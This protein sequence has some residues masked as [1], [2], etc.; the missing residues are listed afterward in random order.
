MSGFSADW[1]ALREPFDRAARAA[2]PPAAFA[3]AM[4]A[5]RRGGLADAPLQVVDLGSG[6]GANLRALAPRLGG[7]QRW[8]LVDHDARLLD[9]VPE[10]MAAW[11]PQHGLQ[12]HAQGAGLLLAG[13]ALHLDIARCPV[14]LAHGLD[15]VPFA[16]VQ[17]V[18][19]S[20]L[21]DLVSADWLAA[22]VGRCRAAG[23]AVWW[24][25]NVDERMAWT[26]AA[27]DDAPVHRAFRAHQ[28][29]DK[30]F[31]PALGPAAAPRAAALLAA[32][33]YRVVRR[34]TDW[35]IDGR[36]GALDRS[37]LRAM[38]EGIGAAAAEQAPALADG[39]ARWQAQ[40]C[41]QLDGLRL[42]VGHED[43]M[44]WLP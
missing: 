5:G 28:R 22:L 1:L 18:T 14:E 31:G 10:A 8:R 11:A 27:P 2:G 38:V 16:G 23:A 7:R 26:P 34:Q 29:R 33:G 35:Q 4:T 3:E 21:L 30:G 39:V 17:L 24:A 6:T 12:R 36:R 44:G 37:M 20:A 25:L 40:K 19:A 13:E 41:A 32:A 9:A 15:T 43:V 42:R